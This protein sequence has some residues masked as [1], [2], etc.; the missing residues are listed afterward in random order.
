MSTLH[1]AFVD[2]TDQTWVSFRALTLERRETVQ[3]YL[4]YLVEKEVRTAKS[5]RTRQLKRQLKA[6]EQSGA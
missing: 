1:K 4:G 2:C 6:Q 3:S 5:A